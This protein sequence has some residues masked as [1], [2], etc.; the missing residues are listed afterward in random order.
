VKPSFA[1]RRLLAILMIAG[2]ALAPVSRPVMAAPSSQSPHEMMADQMT[3]SE[4]SPSEMA[5]DTMDEMASEMPCCPSKAPAP[6]D[7]DKCVFMAACGSLCFAGV[8]ATISHPFPILSDTI[9]LQRNDARP[10][11]LG[12][13]PP[14]HPPRSL[15]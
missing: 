1:I 12:H 6:V 11:G 3:P 13:P 5:A 15:V 9:A 2:L 14:E 8:S 7:C 4:M 10:D